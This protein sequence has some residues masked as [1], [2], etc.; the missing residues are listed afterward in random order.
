MKIPFLK[1][2]KIYYL[3]S[4]LLVIGSVYAILIY[5]LKFGMEFTGGSVLEISVPNNGYSRDE[6]ENKLKPLNIGEMT[7]SLL[8]NN[9]ASLRLPSLSDEMR[10]KIL[11]ALPEVREERFE[12]IGPLI[13]KEL[14]TKTEIAIALSLM[15]I[16]LYI[17]IAFR[18]LT[19]PAKPWQYG[20]AALIALFHDLI[21]P[22]GV[23]AVLGEFYN[24]EITIPFVAAL[25]TVLGYSISDTVVVYD[26]IRENYPK[27]KGKSFYDI[28]EESLNQTIIRSVTTNV[29]AILA[30][31]CIYFFGGETLK[32]FAL[33]M[34]IGIISGSYSSIFVATPLLVTW[35]KQI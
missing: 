21:I 2:R 25:L 16:M 1:Y 30:L 13:G 26:R 33:A 6:I 4:A 3:F 18:K 24:V 11:T 35:N 34:V 23:F 5:G 14:K 10:G 20:V 28:V 7:I 22:L 32:Y 9:N 15:G 29:A 12:T 8:S 17:V 31:V 27:N 19:Y